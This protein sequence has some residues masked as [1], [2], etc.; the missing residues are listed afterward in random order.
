MQL[1][2]IGFTQKTAEEFFSLLKKAGVE[3]LVDIRLHPDSQLSGFAKRADLR[4]F[5]KHLIGC[6]YEYEASL[7][8]SEEL[9][10]AYRTTKDWDAYETGYR[11]LLKERDLPQALERAAF[12]ERKC[13]LLCSEAEASHCHRRVA[14]E[15]MQRHWKDV[16]IIHL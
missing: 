13:C 15:E 12:E 14:A 1:Y 5:L 9:L 11:Q 7:A 16:E 8:P 3:R 4:Y 6:E 2:T 10:K